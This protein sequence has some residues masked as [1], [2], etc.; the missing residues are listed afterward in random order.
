MGPSLLKVV[1]GSR[2][3]AG[4]YSPLLCTT[5]TLL[6]HIPNSHL[7]TLLLGGRKIYG[8][9]AGFRALLTETEVC[10]GEEVCLWVP[11]L[12]FCPAG[13]VADWVVASFGNH[14]LLQGS[15][16]LWPRLLFHP[17]IATLWH[18][19]WSG[20][21][22]LGT[23]N[24]VQILGLHLHAIV[25]SHFK[26]LLWDVLTAKSMESRKLLESHFGTCEPT[27]PQRLKMSSGARLPLAYGR[28]STVANKQSVTHIFIERSPLQMFAITH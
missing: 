7:T 23:I 1:H 17:P 18:L 15:L 11:A 21:L 4:P 22:V 2:N 5:V 3:A 6:H 27:Q 28:A 9:C 13:L 19:Y 24:L 8:V 16:P 12:W 10:T 25:W 20:D 26:S 14:G